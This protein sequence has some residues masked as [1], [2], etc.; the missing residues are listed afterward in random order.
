MSQLIKLLNAK[1]W[2]VTSVQP[3]NLY[4]FVDND[5]SNNSEEI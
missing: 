3:W 5:F 4:Q 2:T 1:S